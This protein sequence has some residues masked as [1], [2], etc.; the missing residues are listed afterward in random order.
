[1]TGRHVRAPHASPR[2]H[3]RARFVGADN[4]SKD[5]DAMHGHQSPPYCHGGIHLPAAPLGVALIDC[6]EGGDEARASAD[7]ILSAQGARQCHDGT[8]M[9]FDSTRPPQHD[10][11][12]SQSGLPPFPRG[13]RPI[14][15]IGSGVSVHFILFVKGCQTR[16]RICLSLASRDGWSGLQATA[17][18]PPSCPKFIA[19][20]NEPPS[21]GTKSQRQKGGASVLGR[22]THRNGNINFLTSSL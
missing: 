3:H 12:V 17:L 15:T 10:V 16:C 21:A 22:I 19:Q 6:R 20:F 4:Q 5:Y 1:M 7:K 9:L 13:C 18:T 2:R 8:A 14:V 11:R